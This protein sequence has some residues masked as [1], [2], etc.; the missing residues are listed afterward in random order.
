MLR[1]VSGHQRAEVCVKAA[2]FRGGRMLLLKRSPTLTAFPSTW[3]MPG[4][5][6]ER[7][8]SLTQALRREIRE[9]TGFAAVVGRPFWTE[10]FDYPLAGG[11]SA[12]SIEIDFFCATPSGGAPRLDPRE[13]TRFAW[14]RRYDAR[15]FPA[16]AAVRAIVR[17]AIAGRAGEEES[18]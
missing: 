14:L 2:L 7:G 16:P 5:H 15:S 12:R 6:V 9:E 4:G 18:S 1:R 11:R 8:E 3:D 10:F 13:H 17:R